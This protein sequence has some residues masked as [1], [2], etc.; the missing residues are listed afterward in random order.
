M[1]LNENTTVLVFTG[2][3]YNSEPELIT[4]IALYKNTAKLVFNQ[5][6]LINNII[7]ENGLFCLTLH[8][9]VIEYI[10]HKNANTT[11]IYKIWEEKGTLK[12]GGPYGIAQNN[13]N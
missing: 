5:N 13:F 3:P 1:H 4:I 10:G 8:D 6:M 2:Y 9:S 7:Q 11:N 12:F